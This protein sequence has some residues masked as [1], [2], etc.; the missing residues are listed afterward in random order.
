[1][2]ELQEETT[3]KKIFL[4]E[5]SLQPKKNAKHKNRNKNKNDY[6]DEYD[7]NNDDMN[8]NDDHDDDD[9]NKNEITMAH[10]FASEDIDDNGDDAEDI[11]KPRKKRVITQSK[12]W[13][14]MQLYLNREEQYNLLIEIKNNSNARECIWMLQEIN[15]KIHGYKCQDI[16]KQLYSPNEFVDTSY[17]IELL[18]MS[19]LHCYYCNEDMFVLYEEVR[20]P[21]QWSLERI[22]NKIGHNKE[23]VE[24]SCLSCNLKRKTMYHERFLFTK[25]LG[26][27]VKLE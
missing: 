16:E 10:A 12:K 26:N 20:N 7:M 8:N 17:V 3:I 5:K 23:N 11:Y 4:T 27:I 21:K 18:V 2:N 25:R 24:I 19:K 22:D 13:E 9:K 1:M 15:K 6:E 14:T